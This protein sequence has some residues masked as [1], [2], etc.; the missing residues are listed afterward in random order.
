[1][2]VIVTGPRTILNTGE[3]VVIDRWTA[4]MVNGRRSLGGML[5]DVTGTVHGASFISIHT[6]IVLDHRNEP[7]M[8]S[9]RQRTPH[10][11]YET[12]GP[13]G[14]KLIDRATMTELQKQGGFD[15][16]WSALFTAP[17]TVRGRSTDS[18]RQGIQDLETALRYSR[19]ALE[20]ALMIEDGI[21]T[22]VP[23]RHDEKHI[24]KLTNPHG[25]SYDRHPQWFQASARLVV[26]GN[27]I[28]W[29][30]S[31]GQPVRYLEEETP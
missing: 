22:V 23:I 11:S 24:P 19:E 29:L 15:T 30:T 5:R 1:M 18:I 9:Q 2:K 21:V 26:D 7:R 27:Q 14:Q 6:E 10:S 20:L 8:W 25:T 3:P 16:V 28:G 31:T 4:Y 13:G 17:D 12:F